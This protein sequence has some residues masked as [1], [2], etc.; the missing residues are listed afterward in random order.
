L[1]AGGVTLLLLVAVFAA[2]LPYLSR[3]IANN[4]PATLPTAAQLQEH[5]AEGQRALADGNFNLAL[6]EFNKALDLRER[7]SDL[8]SAKQQRDLIQLQRQSDLLARLYNQPLQDLLKEALLTPRAEEWTL[9]F[10][11]VH[12][13]RTI[14]LDDVVQR[15]PASGRLVLAC[16]EL[17]AGDEKAVVSVD[18][19]KIL[20]MMPLEPARRLIFGGRLKSA[21]R[22]E[23]GAWVL[24]FEPESGVLMTDADA[25]AA[26][27][28]TPLDAEAVRTLQ[29]QA[30][31]LQ[32]LPAQQPA[33]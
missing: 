1:L 15:D 24:H 19:L 18:D 29:R 6:G 10:E 17:R 4:Q 20:Q 14:L 2:L 32:E 8:L 27:W 21:A 25:A 7:Q 30:E 33:R 31:R 22:E 3:P 12:K 23:R 9:R 28:P 16:F 26:C 13:G 5:I 11:T